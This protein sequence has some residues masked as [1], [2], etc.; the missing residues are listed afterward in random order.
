MTDLF[1]QALA[2]VSLSAPQASSVAARMSATYGLRS[3][4]SSASVALE[5]SLASRLPEVLAMH[6]GTMWQQT[7][8]AKATPQ[9]RRILAHIQSG[10]RTSG[11]GFTGWP[12]ATARDY[13]SAN[14]TANRTNPN[15]QHHDGLTLLDAARMASWPTP[16]AG[17]PAQKGYNAAGNTDSSRRTVELASWPTT[18]SR[19]WKGANE[20]GNELTHNARPLNKVARLA[21]WPTPLALPSGPMSNGSPVETAKPGQLNPAHSRW[22][23]GYPTEW[24]DCAP[25]AMRSSRKSPRRSSEQPSD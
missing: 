10:L 16:M 24:D 13:F 5:L 3:S 17:T 7:W 15:S 2:H 8:K 22:L 18:A 23:M 21:S 9:R 12:T 11:S 20:P 4:A 19:D 25:T 6:G 14:R 1:G